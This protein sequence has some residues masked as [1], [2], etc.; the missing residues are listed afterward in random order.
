VFFVQL[1]IANIL[2]LLGITIAI[3][4]LVDDAIVV[5]EC[6]QQHRD[7]GLP[8]MRAARVGTAEVALP[9]TLSTLTTVLAFLPIIFMSGRQEVT[10]FT[11]AIGMPLVWAVLAEPRRRP[12]L[13][14]ARDRRL[15]PRDV[16]G[17]ALDHLVSV[18]RL[19]RRACGRLRASIGDGPPSPVRPALPVDR[20]LRPPS[21]GGHGRCFRRPTS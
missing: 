14:S 6:I 9:V 19:V 4:M 15:D 3:G 21:R 12:R 1:R 10:F 2:S 13:R 20:L 7:R 18:E 8:P 17:S 11:S 16:P 5:V